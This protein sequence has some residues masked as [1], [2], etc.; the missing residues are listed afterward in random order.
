MNLRM[1]KT[2]MKSPEMKAF[3][4]EPYNEKTRLVIFPWGV[5]TVEVPMWE[6]QVV[7]PKGDPI[8]P[9]HW[10]MS[11][12]GRDR[13]MQ[14]MWIHPCREAVD[15]FAKDP[16]GEYYHFGTGEFIVFRK[17]KGSLCHS[18]EV[19]IVPDTQFARHDVDLSDVYG[20]IA[21]LNTHD[22]G[23][24]SGLRRD[25]YSWR[26]RSLP[27]RTI[28]FNVTSKGYDWILTPKPVSKKK[29]CLRRVSSSM[30]EMIDVT[31]ALD[32]SRLEQIASSTEPFTD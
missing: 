4:Q 9:M 2:F 5:Q 27:D 24:R 17:T 31:M 3:S 28:R 15:I 26:F 8:G 21:V 12:Y 25:R 23:I 29:W 1:I 7:V 32:I 18:M 13:Y 16:T 14:G 20:L 11:P 30:R 10:Q 19:D 22:A 6:K